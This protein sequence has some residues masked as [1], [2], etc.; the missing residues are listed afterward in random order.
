MDECP[1]NAGER[2]RPYIAVVD[3]TGIEGA[4]DVV[5]DTSGGLD[6]KLASYSASLEKQGLRLERVTAPVEKLIIDKIEKVPVEN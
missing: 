5:L 3:R 4:W 6:E 2:S 1:P